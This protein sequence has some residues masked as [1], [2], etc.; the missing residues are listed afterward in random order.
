MQLPVIK[1]LAETYTI[2]Q[3]QAAENALYE[4]QK[5]A[6]DIEGKDEGEQLTHVLAAISIL[7]DVEK[8]TELRMAIRNYTQR[9]RNSIS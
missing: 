8:G 7:E 1:L 4:E 9:V 2:Q 5:P 3:L 6:I